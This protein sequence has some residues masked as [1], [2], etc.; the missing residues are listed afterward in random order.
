MSYGTLY[1]LEFPD[2]FDRTIQVLIEEEDY[3]GASTDIKGGESPLEIQWNTPSDFILDPINGSTATIRLMSE[4]DFQFLN[5]YTNSNRKY[6]VTINIDATLEWKGFLQPDQYQEDYKQIPYDNE[7]IASD[8]LGFLK[9][10]AWDRVTIETEMS[11]L[12]AILAKTDLE[13]DLYEGLNIYELHH[14]TTTADSPL[15]Q[16]YIN[17]KAF[18][19]KTYYDAL[20]AL[21]FKYAATIKQDRGHWVIERPEEKITAYQRRLWTESLGVFTYDSTALYDPIVSSTSATAARDDLVRITAG[22]MFINPA[23]RNY[24]ITQAYGKRDNLIQNGDFT[25]WFDKRPAFWGP[26][27][28]VETHT[29]RSADKLKLLPRTPQVD[30]RKW[31]II[32]AATSDVFK[33]TIDYDIFCTASLD[34]E[35]RLSITSSI[36]TRWWDFDNNTWTHINTKYSRNFTSNNENVKIDIITSDS[37]VADIIAFTFEMFLPVGVFDAG[38]VI[39]NS[40]IMRVLKETTSSQIEEPIE[41]Q[42]S[43]VTIN[44][45][46]NFDGGDYEM[47]LSDL[48]AAQRDSGLVYNGGMWLDA[49]QV[50]PTLSWSAIGGTIGGSLVS[51]LFNSISK[52]LSQPQQVIS[53]PIYSMTL[54]STSVI[55]EVNNSN[56]LFMIR[57]ATWNILEGIW[58]VEGF[59]I[60]V[61]AG[62]ALKAQDG[63]DLLAQDGQTLLA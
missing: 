36:G 25:L 8:Q 34:V 29:E 24:S 3:A 19:G 22:G 6:R 11:M 55:Q 52:L 46:N 35:F 40:I 56:K 43:I 61:G 63:Q 50:S 60:G 23:W 54:F 2:Y 37:G 49:L 32:A 21:L 18:A 33:M 28:G 27:G 12:Q 10:L 44:P 14:N 16:T 62:A 5:L 42:K 47:L 1:T 15:D 51:L 20:K 38:H 26:S 30:L 53:V 31:F 57:R 7:F 59:E 58:D 4:T 48:P 17:T 13:M 41:D 39:I 9:A 45:T